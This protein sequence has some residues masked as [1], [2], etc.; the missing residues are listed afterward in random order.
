[1]TAAEVD[2]PAGRATVTYDPAKTSPANLV[3]AV[4]ATGYTASLP[5]ADQE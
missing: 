5:E 2:Y 1:V 4:N 3:G